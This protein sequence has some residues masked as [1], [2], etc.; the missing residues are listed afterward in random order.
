VCESAAFDYVDVE[1]SLGVDVGS[2]VAM[3]LQR[4]P[5]LN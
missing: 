4:V 1:D 3:R 5:H 2:D